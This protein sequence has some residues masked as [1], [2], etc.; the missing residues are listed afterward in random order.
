MV[1]FTTFF[2]LVLL[3]LAS[4]EEVVM[5]AGAR[6]CHK[7]WNC[8]GNNRCWDDCKNKYNGMGLCDLYAA[9]AVPKQC[10]CAYKC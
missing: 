4:D 2:L 8:K 1:K 5:R 6:D 9:P 7:V 3:I 10:F